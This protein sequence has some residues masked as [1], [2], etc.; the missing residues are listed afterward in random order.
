MSGTSAPIQ[1]FSLPPDEQRARADAIDPSASVFLSANAGSGK[2]TILTSRVIRLL[3]EGV[4]PSR[5]LCLTYTKAAAAEM[6]NRI[7][8][9]LSG[10]VRL[11][12]AALGAELARLLQRP[13][14]SADI[15]RARALFARAV[16]TPGGLKLQTIHAFAERLLHLF[17]FEANVPARFTVMEE[18]TKAEM[19][20]AAKRATIRAALDAPDAPLGA[21]FMALADLTGEDGFDGIIRQAT[22]L[23]RK[24]RT[25]ALGPED[26]HGMLAAALEID[27]A[28]T[29]ARIA[30][31]I[32][33]DGGFGPMLWRATVDAFGS[34]KERSWE[35]S[36][37]DRLRPC[38]SAS[39][40]QAQADALLAG[41]LNEK[42]EPRK[43]F[44]T[45]TGAGLKPEI[46]DAVQ[47]ALLRLPALSEQLR[48]ARVLERSVALMVV[49]DDVL[50]RY[51]DEKQARAL[52]DF[53]DL[54]DRALDLVSRDNGASWVLRKLDGGIDHVLIDEAQDTTPE[55]WRIAQ[56]LTAEFFSGEGARGARRTVFAVG[57]E[58]QSIY[59][60][61]GARPAE[62]AANRT[63]F[64]TQAGAV[65]AR[66]HDLKL[67]LSFR[68]VADVLSAVDAVFGAPERYRGLWSENI[69][70]THTTA[71]EKAPGYVDLWPLEPPPEKSEPDAW[72]PVD[73]LGEGSAQVRL[74]NRLAGHIAGQVRNGHFEND[75]APV[76]PGDILILVQRRDAFF[77]AVIRALKREG[78]AVAGADRVRLSDEIA[79]MD[80]I[81]AARVALL[82]EDDL[83]LAEA[84]KSPLIGLDDADLIAL[85]PR[86]EASLFAALAAS[87]AAQHRAAR[88]I[89]ET[90]RALAVRETPHGFFAHILGAMGGRKALLTRLG[91]DAADGIELFLSGVQA[92]SQRAPASLLHEIE[93]FAGLATDVK[94]DQEEAGSSVRVLTVHGAKG[95]E[96]RM[97]Y[98]PD[99]NRTPVGNRDGALFAVGH[100]DD[101]EREV[102][103]WAQRKED[104]PALI[105]AR[106]ASEQA[107]K[108]DEYRRLFYVAM[109]RARDRLVIAGWGA[110]DKVLDKDNWYAMAH[111]ALSPHA[112]ETE[113]DGAQVLRWRSVAASPARPH[114]GAD[115]PLPAPEQLPEWLNRVAPPEEERTLPPLRPSRAMDAADQI[116]SPQREAARQRGDLA[117]LLLERLPEVP[118]AERDALAA[119]LLAARAPHL[120][121]AERERI[122]A[123]LRDLLRAPEFTGLFGPE[124][125]AEVALAGRVT[126]SSGAP[127]EILGRI[128]RLVIE[129]DRIRIA[130][131]KTGRGKARNRDIA[132]LALYRALLQAIYPGRAVEGVLVHTADATAETIPAAALE[133]AFAKL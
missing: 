75:G 127:R 100:A 77:E 105:E 78:V 80:L 23:L 60:F 14:R 36:F 128:D 53:D 8:G 69:G 25:G 11:D 132:Q 118:E 71:R 2:T 6:Q 91:P 30:Q 87:G 131:F 115:V 31:R 40:P 81:A 5:I 55:M 112:V 86:R 72:D 50:G 108:M 63:W 107:A 20:D 102:L 1:T 46:A 7:F 19:L 89:V 94:R 68:T 16:E 110:P 84:L 74:A 41:F 111:A 54:I 126:L 120:D 44:L 15:G 43:Q 28:E 22:P 125:R 88:A 61:Q 45:K 97:V 33:A 130:D 66:F 106:R 57:D 116:L 73:A 17:P 99:C 62:F 123:P 65:E 79:V 85:A 29:P 76:R 56:A 52:V 34:Y 93:A 121:A 47:D 95:L 101:P 90:W 113:E 129:P 51:R 103:L 67:Q 32:V 114:S 49:V 104:R 13:P 39:G 98:L 27:P 96:A 48:R 10:W 82:P 21:A 92:R 109:T 64:G 133:A 24:A 124:S 38:L 122:A 37:A 35:R 70:T 83:A 117:H 119:R 42:G 58:K 18:I 59:S 9:T 26:W 3:L 4:E 12:D